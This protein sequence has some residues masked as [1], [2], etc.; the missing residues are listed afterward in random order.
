MASRLLRPVGLDALA[1]LSFGSDVRGLDR[2]RPRRLGVYSLTSR[3]CQGFSGN[4]VMPKT[5]KP[6]VLVLTADEAAELLAPIGDGGQQ[7]FHQGILNQLQ[8]G[9]LAIAFDDDQLGKLIRY[10]TQY[11]PGGFQSRLRK[12]FRRPL[13]D[14][15]AA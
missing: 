1:T 10:M 12:A 15:I 7:G 3:F 13:L 6:I 14:L 4:S 9:N 5:A 2:S 11:G 8:N